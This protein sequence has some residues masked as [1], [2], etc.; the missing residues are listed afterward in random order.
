MKRGVITFQEL[1]PSLQ[2]VYTSGA[3]PEEPG[4]SFAEYRCGRVK[5]SLTVALCGLGGVLLSMV[6]A[7]FVDHLMN[8]AG[9]TLAALSSKGNWLVFGIAVLVPLFFWG[10]GLLCLA[11]SWEALQ[12]LRRKTA[13]LNGLAQGRRSSGLLLSPEA[14]VWRVAEAPELVVYLARADVTGVESQHHQGETYWV[15]V[16]GAGG[17][18]EREGISKRSIGRWV[19][20]G[21][22]APHARAPHDP[23]EVVRV[24]WERRPAADPQAAPPPRASAAGL[25]PRQASRQL[26]ALAFSLVALSGALAAMAS[27]ELLM[28]G[29]VVPREDGGAL[30]AWLLLAGLVAIPIVVMWTLGV[31]LARLDRAAWVGQVAMG[32]V[33]PIGCA[34]LFM[35]GLG[36]G[37]WGWALGAVALVQ[38]AS[39]AVLLRQGVRWRFGIGPDAVLAEI[40]AREEVRVADLAARFQ[41]EPA[42]IEALLER[43]IALGVFTGAW[44]REAGVVLS[45]DTLLAREELSRCP[46]CGAALS[47][48][49]N[50]AHCRYCG[51]EFAHLTGLDYPMPSPIGVDVTVAID[52]VLIYLASFLAAAWGAMFLAQRVS[53]VDG[54]AEAL[55][56]LVLCAGPLALARATVAVGRALEAGARSGWARHLWLHPWSLPYLTRRRV[57]TLYAAAIEPLE[58]RL[59]AEGEL[60][61]Q[62]LA[63]HMRIS[64]TH[65]SEAALYLSAS[66]TFDAI[67]DWPKRRLLRRDRLAQDGRTQCTSCGAP[68]RLHHRCAFCGTLA[69]QELPANAARAPWRSPRRAESERAWARA[70]RT[71]SLAALATGSFALGTCSPSL[72]DKKADE[73]SQGVSA[74]P[75]VSPGASGARA[76]GRQP[77]G[78]LRRGSP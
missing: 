3:L 1:P 46:H 53:P 2:A 62:A 55:T 50:V 29:L 64:D 26:R 58:Q 48:L 10:F 69:R 7:E 41:V 73:I 68:L 20:S 59:A 28:R 34:A 36:D 13:Y 51:T 9:E 43:C 5:E 38:G 33:A 75:G 27:W 22:E 21:A 61:F 32:I 45:V 57:R 71:L 30:A 74:P 47:A 63:S 49:G 8:S 67:I 54:L 15:L 76:P 65:A 14:L 70:R 12:R 11:A 72:K 31:R 4:W 44:D 39:L 25:L 78:A 24:W 19:H 56:W 40:D 35:A 66:G 37:V 6:G 60:S 16:W 42:D 18:S 17:S 77:S 52:R 23:A